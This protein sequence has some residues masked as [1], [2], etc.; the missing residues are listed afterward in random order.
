MAFKAILETLLALLS[1]YEEVSHSDSRSKDIDTP[2]TSRIQVLV[3]SRDVVLWSFVVIL[4]SFHC[5][6]S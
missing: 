1:M 3:D 6:C 5:P 2:S 4:I